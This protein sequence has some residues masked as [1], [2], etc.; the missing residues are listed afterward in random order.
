M[1]S[2]EEEGDTRLFNMATRDAVW[3]QVSSTGQLNSHDWYWRA[4]PSG[5]EAGREAARTINA[6][7][8]WFLNKY[9]KGSTDPMPALADYP[10]VINFKE[11]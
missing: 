4:Y 8:L 9:L 2:T 1:Y 6:Y 10:R 3:F 11:K 5:V 7:T